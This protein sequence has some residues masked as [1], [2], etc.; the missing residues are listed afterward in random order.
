MRSVVN[1]TEY[2][3]IDDTHVIARILL[4]KT[5]Y[6]PLDPPYQ[7]NFPVKLIVEDSRSL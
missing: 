3:Y 6:Q 7:S 2:L 1:T 4:K 5:Q